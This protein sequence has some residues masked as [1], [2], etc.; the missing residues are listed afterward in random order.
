MPETPTV[1][2]ADLPE[3]LHRKFSEYAREQGI[4][5]NEAIVRLAAATLEMRELGERVG[6]AMCKR[7]NA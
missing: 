7:T 3:D 4:S 1:D 6:A 5:L 2:A